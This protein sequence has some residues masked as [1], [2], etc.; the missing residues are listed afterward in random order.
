MQEI[1]FRSGR[2][3]L[4]RKISHG[5][6][7]S[8]ILRLRPERAL[9]ELESFLLSIDP[10]QQVRVIQRDIHIPRIKRERLL[11]ISLRDFGLIGGHFDQCSQSQE[12]GLI[13]G[14]HP[15]DLGYGCLSC[16]QL[17]FGSRI[18]LSGIQLVQTQMQ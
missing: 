15:T 13:A 5:G 17:T 12:L 3:R 11:K 1:F 6:K 7:R 18:L 8:L 4:S 14:I 9:V 2:I 16:L 10:P